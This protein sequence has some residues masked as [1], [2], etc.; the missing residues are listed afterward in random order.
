MNAWYRWCGAGL[1]A[2]VLAG[3]GGDSGG[4]A[5]AE[6]QEEAEAAAEASPQPTPEPEVEPFTEPVEIEFTASLRS[7]RRLMVEGESNLPD[8]TRLLVVVERELSG[9]RWQS[10]INLDDGS[11]AAGPFGPGSGL[12]D[13]GY[14]ITVNLPEASVQPL[15]VRRRLGDQGEHLT[16]PLVTTSRHG[17]GQV[18]STS[19]RFLV[20]NEPR[21]TTDQ[22]EVQG[23]E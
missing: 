23:I 10:R 7:D 19:R 21:R 8:D 4:S 12:P 3:C 17:L 13:G 22:V 18:A 11:F 15:A 6:P 1:V 14:T 9:V 5:A 2:L 16:G 20:G